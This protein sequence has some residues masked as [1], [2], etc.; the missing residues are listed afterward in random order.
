MKE[1]HQ[2]DLNLLPPLKALLEARGVSQAARRLHISQPTMSRHLA[3]L[4]DALDDPLL[5]R[6]GD[7]Y[8]LTEKARR[9]QKKLETLLPEMQSIFTGESAPDAV[10]KIFAIAAPDY[11]VKYVLCDIIAACVTRNPGISF[12]VESWNT[13]TKSKLIHGELHFAI[14]LDEAFPHDMVRHVIGKD[15]L[16]LLGRKGHPALATAPASLETALKFPFVDVLTGGGWQEPVERKL[17]GLKQARNVRVHINSY[18][19][20]FSIA[21]QSDLLLIV[22]RHVAANS[23]AARG[24]AWRD[25][26]LDMPKLRYC[27]WWHRVYQDNA[28]HKWFRENIMPEI[29][30]RPALINL[31]MPGEEEGSS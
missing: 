30:T 17:A 24:L 4:R 16:L 13:Y 23:H 3:K 25:F 5:M 22:P 11:T 21:A 29:L 7:Q 8:V 1:L 10:P 9:I 18:E 26:P 28:T 19:E 2:I 12:V 20:A 14:S 6:A 15:T 27:L 31:K